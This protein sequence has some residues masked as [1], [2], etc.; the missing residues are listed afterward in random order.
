MKKKKLTKILFL[1]S[2]SS[3]VITLILE[4]SQRYN[5]ILFILRHSTLYLGIAF[6]VSAVVSYFYSIYKRYFI[7]RQINFVYL[8]I[9][10][11]IL[12]LVALIWIADT[13]LDFIAENEVPHYINE[14][15]Y[16]EHNN[17]IYESILVGIEP[18][19]ELIEKTDNTLVIH[20]EEKCECKQN[21]HYIEELNP[22]SD[23]ERYIDGSVEIVIDIIVLYNNENSIDRYSIEETRLITYEPD[24]LSKHYGYVSRKLE[25]YNE[26]STDVFKAT[27]SSYYFAKFMTEQEFVDTPII[28]HHDFTNVQA[29]Q[30]VVTV[31][32]TLDDANSEIYIMEVLEEGTDVNELALLRRS[33]TDSNEMIISFEESPNR[34]VPE[35][36]WSFQSVKSEV[37][38]RFI[39]DDSRIR[40]EQ[41][42]NEANVE[43]GA[44]FHE[45]LKEFDYSIDKYTLSTNNH[46]ID[47]NDHSNTGISKYSDLFSSTEY[48][49]IVKRPKYAL[50][51]ILYPE[52]PFEI[53]NINLY[54]IDKDDF[55]YTVSHYIDASPYDPFNP[56]ENSNL[57]FFDEYEPSIDG[58]FNYSSMLFQ[59]T[60]FPTMI[61]ENNQMMNFI[62]QE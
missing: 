24:G 17:K 8:N 46:T 15:L 29:S 48:I 7:K 1:C 40:Y 42:Y 16:D 27:Q 12:L 49:E 3:F 43:R 35:L 37:S 62:L 58:Y 59:G 28:N 61:Y 41:S 57:M 44:G 21:S 51:D 26:Y 55:G 22:N 2:L 36:I 25:V 30:N 60:Y 39:I 54:L 33:E 47:G 31:Y 32:R 4:F 5:Q 13:R 11:L 52:N 18:V 19:V 10:T 14:I 38:G 45:I 53:N 23:L 56:H 50:E 20:I 34:N 9:P 6:L